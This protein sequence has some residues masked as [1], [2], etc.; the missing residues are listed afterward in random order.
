MSKKLFFILLLFE[1]VVGGSGH[2][3]ELGPITARMLFFSIAVILAILYYSYRRVIKRDVFIIVFSFT[4]LSIIGSIVGLLNNAPMSFIIEDFK[5]LS[6]F[7]ILLFFSI[8]INESN[9]IDLISRIIKN[10]SIFIAVIYLF[11]LI[12]LFTEKIDFPSFYK[13]QVSSGEIIFRNDFIFFYKGFLY[14]CIGFFFNLFSNSKYKLIPLLFLYVCIVLT[15]TR[16]FILFTTI[17]LIYFLFFI[18]KNKLIKIFTIILIPIILFFTVPLLLEYVGDK[19]DSDSMRYIQIQQVLSG[20]NP[21]SL[22]LG[23][24]LGV[25]IDIRPIHMELSFLEIFHKQGIIGIIFWLCIYI[26]I[27][28]LFFN[29]KDKQIRN[30]AYPFILS[31]VFIIL[32]SI[33]NPFMNNPIGLTMILLTIVVLSKLLEQQKSI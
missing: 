32:Q 26:H 14:L 20:I 8:S 12:L 23:H 27:F 10:G 13:N 1:L 21:V 2:Y 5:P 33:T 7:Y 28:F 15:L 6:F 9:Y 18:N 22:I 11:T 19:A 25:G 29:I 16:G 30:K 24:G 17:L 4:F 3:T 31:V